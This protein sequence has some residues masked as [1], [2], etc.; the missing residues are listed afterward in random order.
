MLIDL[1]P[2]KIK[3]K[4]K[5]MNDQIFI[6]DNMMDAFARKIELQENFTQN[7]FKKF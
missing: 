5:R 3:T 6:N 4:G 7:I 1:H 2:Q